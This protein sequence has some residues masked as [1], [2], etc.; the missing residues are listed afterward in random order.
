MEKKQKFSRI[1]ISALNKELALKYSIKE[2]WDYNFMEI[3]LDY[4]KR[5]DSLSNLLQD[6]FSFLPDSQDDF[7]FNEIDLLVFLIISANPYAKTKVCWLIIHCHYPLPLIY[8]KDDS[9]KFCENAFIFLLL[10]LNCNLVLNFK[11]GKPKIGS[12]EFCG[13]M[14]PIEENKMDF[15][16]H[17][18]TPSALAYFSLENIE[19]EPDLVLIDFNG[20]IENFKLFENLID[21]LIALANLV[22]VHVKN[23]ESKSKFQKNEWIQK[24]IKENLQKFI[25]IKRDCPKGTQEEEP[26]NFC[27]PNKLEV[28]ANRI[29]L[30]LKNISTFIYSTLEKCPNISD[31][32]LQDLKATFLKDNTS[33]LQ[34]MT[35]IKAALKPGF[36]CQRHLKYQELIKIQKQ[37]KDTPNEKNVILE[38]LSKQVDVQKIESHY[39][40]LMKM[41]SYMHFSFL[42]W[43]DKKIESANKKNLRPLLNQY[44][45]WI[46]D[47]MQTSIKLVPKPRSAEEVANNKAVQEALSCLFK[48]VKKLE[49]Q[50]EENDISLYSLY[51]EIT[52]L[53]NFNKTNPEFLAFV[54]NYVEL[55]LN[56]MPL[57]IIHGTPYQ[58]SCEMLKSFFSILDVQCPK[59]K[60]YV[61]SIIGAQSSAKSS[62]LNSLFGCSMQSREGRCTRGVYASYAVTSENE[63]LIILDTEGLLSLE[64]TCDKQ[65]IQMVEF[66][67]LCSN[68]VIL[69]FKGQLGAKIEDAIHEA[70]FCLN[71]T[72]LK[73]NARK[74][75]VL[76]ALRDEVCP[77]YEVIEKNTEDCKVRLE[78][79]LKASKVE[80][81]DFLDSTCFDCFPI[82]CAIEKTSK[83]CLKSGMIT[84]NKLYGRQILSM[85]LKI[86]EILKSKYS[87]KLLYSS[88]SEF[89]EKTS[90]IFEKI[91]NWNEL[92]F[93]WKSTLDIH[94]EGNTKS[95]D[96]SDILEEDDK[97][98][99][100]TDFTKFTGRSEKIFVD[101]DI[102]KLSKECEKTVVNQEKTIKESENFVCNQGIAKLLEENKKAAGP[103]AI[104]AEKEKK[105]II[106]Q[107]I[108]IENDK[109]IYVSQE[110]KVEKATIIKTNNTEKE[111]K[112]NIAEDSKK[113]TVPHNIAVDIEKATVK[114]A[115]NVEKDKKATISQSIAL[116]KNKKAIVYQAINLDKKQIAISQAI[117]EEKEKKADVPE[118]IIKEKRDKEITVSQANNVEKAG[119]PQV[120][121]AEENKNNIAA[122]VAT[123]LL[124]EKGNHE[125]TKKQAKIS[126][127]K[128]EIKLGKKVLE[129]NYFDACCPHCHKK[130]RIFPKMI[131]NIDPKMENKIATKIVC[132][133]DPANVEPS[134]KT[135]SLQTMKKTDK[136]GVTKRCLFK[137][138]KTN[139]L[140]C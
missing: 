77:I 46:G 10:S 22:L 110:M 58:Y 88:Y 138:L 117:N 61:V 123:T 67:L 6:I 140:K 27:L 135:T 31:D 116:E 65:S 2:N 63:Q 108:N 57:H 82:V 131:R 125:D 23:N 96:P 26:P 52:I 35:S 103:K 109:K 120:I 29:E 137:M 50:I 11:F 38:I 54:N 128:H 129:T 97:I 81:S 114:Q 7:Q 64:N 34:I 48:K 28:N 55:F 20:S 91:S 83:I 80:M 14:F 101:Q 119:V 21:K 99:T 4:I 30:K 66:V 100:L 75:R 13:K 90:Q 9:L 92:D 93:I 98:D 71:I 76:F 139:K 42:F 5:K 49:L 84:Y 94:E 60:F 62:I 102:S 118:A 130:F 8:W 12:S 132:K 136:S 59:S 25:I 107:D 86:I 56:G 104:N 95:K 45:E 122:K 127:H 72:G 16:D 3:I 37:N 24:I 79:G 105:P 44:I 78:E 106:K 111:S 47:I 73:S 126:E 134:G 32:S 53:Y 87:E 17:E 33:E 74:P 1:F 43:L 115:I 39:Y 18:M 36:Q 133:P 41:T 70:V 124:E 68:L 51:S 85:R 40:D 121:N 15:R 69:N 89:Y 113:S 19:G 112:A